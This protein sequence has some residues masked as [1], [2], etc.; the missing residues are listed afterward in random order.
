MSAAGWNGKRCAVNEAPVPSKVEP[1]TTV[2]TRML[3]EVRG[4][5]TEVLNSLMK[6]P[7]TAVA[8]RGDLVRIL[9]GVRKTVEE[10]LG[11]QKRVCPKISDK[12]G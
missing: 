2:S 5:V 3:E 8:Q 7:T 11:I 6:L 1:T 12:T 4:S 10:P 9:D